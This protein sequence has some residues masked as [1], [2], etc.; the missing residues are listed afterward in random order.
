MSPWIQQRLFLGEMNI[1]SAVMNRA[2]AAEGKPVN[3]FG[4]LMPQAAPRP[5][6]SASGKP[7]SAAAPAGQFANIPAELRPQVQRAM[8]ILGICAFGWMGLTSFAGLTLT[9][10][11][12]SGLLTVRRS[13]W[14]WAITV[15]SVA[16]IVAVIWHVWARYQWA[17]SITPNW[18]KPVLCVLAA[19]VAG[20]IGSVM[21][22]R[23]RGL[24]CFSGVMV[25]L[26]AI[27]S[28]AAIWAAVRWAEMPPESI[29]RA[30]YLRVFAIQ[31]A[32]GWVLLLAALL[33]I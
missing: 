5:G 33:R 24:L 17:Q 9:A 16:G 27:G 15:L 29:N 32:Y 30:L 1:P 7:A 14:P 11:G 6:K 4:A 26:S 31:S 19:L 2:A 25:V 12:T 3:P 23:A 8:L 10:A 13:R 18:V 28:V 22:R 20:A 21:H